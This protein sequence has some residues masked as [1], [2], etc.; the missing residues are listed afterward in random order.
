MNVQKILKEA[1][2]AQA[3]AALVQEKLAATELTGQAGNGLVEVTVNG[4]SEVLGIR[5]QPQAV[6]P[7]D[8]EALEDLVLVAIKNAQSQARARYE[9]EMNR[10]LGSIAG[11]MGG[12]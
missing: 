12:L 4:H 11:M 2:K 7:E 6:D 3:K 8:V 1:Q 9:E 5:I 10:E